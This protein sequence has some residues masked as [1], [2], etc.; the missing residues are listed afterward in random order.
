MR[1]AAL[2]VGLL[3]YFIGTEH[4]CAV[5]LDQD[6]QRQQFSL[7]SYQQL[8]PRLDQLF[9]FIEGGYPLSARTA[10]IFHDFAYQWGQQLL[11]PYRYLKPFDVLVI[12]PHHTLHGIPLHMI[13]LDEAQ[14]FLATAHAITYCSSA[15]LFTRCVDRNPLRK[16]DLSAWEFFTTGDGTPCAPAPPAFGMSVGRDVKGKQSAQYEQL[17]QTFAHH[18]DPQQFRFVGSG[19]KADR[20]IIK[21]PRS[22]E[23]WAATWEVICIVCHGH[24]DAAFPENS[25]L[26]LEGE[27]W[28]QAMQRA[29]SLFPQVLSFFPDHPFRNLPPGLLPR[30][31]CVAELMTISELKVNCST[32]AQLVALFGC[33]TGA[34]QVISGDDC[35]SIAH[36]WLKLG[37][38][39]VLAN[40]WKADFTFIEQWSTYFL[41]NWLQ[42]R[43][44][45]AIAWQQA[46][47][48]VLAERPDLDP[49]LWGP[50]SL[51]G[52]W[53]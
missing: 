36:Q 5:L 50:I 22:Q 33:S 19:V 44:P 35:G 4:I 10:A 11:P 15:T 26:L 12:I 13:W 40:F 28:G 43:Q 27:H 29:I 23:G 38:V 18:F 1:L 41:E 52:D 31:D 51:L 2:R 9:A 25:G 53:L 20:N 47:R 21:H 48:S 6:G 37:A 30:P 8:F 24:Y 46:T 34:S 32:G 14:Q 39:S 49:F 42:K 3:S 7:A 17:A 45:K 16:G